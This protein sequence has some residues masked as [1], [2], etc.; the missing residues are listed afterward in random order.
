LPNTFERGAVLRPIAIVL[1]KDRTHVATSLGT[2]RAEAGSTL[3]S[4]TAM[5]AIV[6]VHLAAAHQA[7]M[8]AT[9]EL[10]AAAQESTDELARYELL[11][12]ATEIARALETHQHLWPTT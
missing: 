1:S 10:L 3:L 9:R 8:L 7:A 4:D 12:A 11:G 2:T 6:S 5:Q